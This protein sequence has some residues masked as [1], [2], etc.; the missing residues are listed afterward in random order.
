MNCECICE[1]QNLIESAMLTIVI[2]IVLYKTILR[3]RIFNLSTGRVAGK[4]LKMALWGMTHRVL[5][6]YGFT[7]G[8]SQTGTMGSMV[9][10]MPSRGF[11]VP[12]TTVSCQ[13][14]TVFRVE[15]QKIYIILSLIFYLLH[16]G[17]RNTHVKDFICFW[18]VQTICC[19]LACSLWKPVGCTHP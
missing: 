18:S 7:H 11:T 14:C 16:G 15:G 10:D 12:I 8:A 4:S 13:V 17:K 1:A 2:V 9:S 5:H 19:C 6:R 3:A